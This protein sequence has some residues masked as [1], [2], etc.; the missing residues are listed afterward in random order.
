MEALVPMMLYDANGRSQCV[1]V[2]TQFLEQQQ[3]PQPQPQPQ[4]SPA[5][6]AKPTGAAPIVPD[7]SQFG[8]HP[9]PARAPQPGFS[10]APGA[11]PP[12]PPAPA[13]AAPPGPPTPAP[14][15]PPPHLRVA[16][17]SPHAP[18]PAA[19]PSPP[20]NAHLYVSNVPPCMNQSKLQLMFSSYGTVV[21]C[22]ITKKAGG[23]ARP[24]GFIQYETPEMAQAAREALDGL[25]VDG[26]CLSVKPAHNDRDRALSSPSSNLYVANL[27]ADCVDAGLRAVFSPYGHVL[28]LVVFK[29]AQTGLCKGS[30]MVRFS[31]T[32]EAT[33]AIKA[34]HGQ[35][36]PGLERPL[37]V[38]YAESKA[39]RASRRTPH[40][41]DS[42][43][44]SSPTESSATSSSAGSS[45]T[46]EPQPDPH[47]LPSPTMLNRQEMQPL[48]SSPFHFVPS[49][50]V[51]VY[52][53]P[54]H[55]VL[56]GQPLPNGRAAPNPAFPFPPAPQFLSLD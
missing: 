41:R 44:S 49:S 52:T 21:K 12:M 25:V 33:A 19:P 55:K 7:L 24:I 23:S 28:S 4:P 34:L 27:P 26:W 35:L 31:S 40:S 22:R 37:E 2:P 8:L 3:Q 6:E 1:Y 20:G 51:G 10:A 47:P 11:G 46:L 30:G 45:P 43:D 38:K 29:D 13:S 54:P 5:A 53:A 32:A 50:S 16:V 18:P 42:F 56:G 15:L 36:L 9:L 39:E 14:L 48:L 17:G